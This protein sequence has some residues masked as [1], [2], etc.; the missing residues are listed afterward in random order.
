MALTENL[1]TDTKA[2][3]VLEGLSGTPLDEL[4]RRYHIAPAQYYEMRDQFVEEGKAGLAGGMSVDPDRTTSDSE[5]FAG[6]SDELRTL[7]IDELMTRV[8]KKTIALFGA[9]SCVLCIERGRPEDECAQACSINCRATRPLQARTNVALREA[10]RSGKPVIAEQRGLCP[11]A[12]EGDGDTNGCIV[13]PIQL[14]QQ[15]Q[16]DGPA[17][18]GFPA[19][20]MCGIE[21]A[22]LSGS[23]VE[24]R[25]LIFSNILS[26]SIDNAIIHTKT[27]RLAYR[28]SL[29]DVK[30]RY[31][32]DEILQSE[33]TRYKR[34]GSDFC[35][36]LVDADNLKQVNDTY[37][38]V[39][40]DH[41]LKDIA[42]ILDTETRDS[43]AV[44][45]FG[46]DEFAVILPE[47]DVDGAR[48]V[49]GRVMARLV[50]A[51]LG[52]AR[53][54]HR[55]VSI[56]I[57]SVRDKTSSSEV[58]EAAD[59]AL[60]SSKRSGKNQI[61]IECVEDDLFTPVLLTN[62]EGSHPLD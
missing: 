36:A 14:K 2:K 22:D 5:F 39:I 57:A 41:V 29:T 53:V 16:P 6:L 11:C 27:A 58:L 7:D 61:S 32:F 48:C 45:R 42:R 47:C 55:T 43:D 4:C 34:Y 15:E 23:L 17:A 21:K 9:R 40:G 20:C 59:R 38:H 56:G 24:H 44:V 26:I 10:A 19:L 25:A 13:L 35:L 37:G 50:D 52:L 3:C 8:V 60:Y 46:G 51:E 31:V 30:T 1:T 18:D 33:W 49:M 28:D 62:V 12:P 54:L